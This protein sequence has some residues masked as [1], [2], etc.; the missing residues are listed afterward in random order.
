MRRKQKKTDWGFDIANPNQSI[1]INFLNR[2]I[3]FILVPY[4]VQDTYNYLNA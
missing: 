4:S 2:V 3:K 1:I